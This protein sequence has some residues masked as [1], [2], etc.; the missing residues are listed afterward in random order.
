MTAQTV[1]DIEAEVPGESFQRNTVQ[2]VV[3]VHERSEGGYAARH[4]TMGC[5]HGPTWLAAVRE[6]LRKHSY[7]V[8]VATPRGSTWRLT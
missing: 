7:A 5:A 2:L 8:R 1:Y 3:T 6:L 4:E